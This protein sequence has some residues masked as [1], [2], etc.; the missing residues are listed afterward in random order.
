MC[1]SNVVPVADFPTAVKRWLFIEP[2]RG[3]RSGVDGGDKTLAWPKAVRGVDDPITAGLA[4][5]PGEI[6]IPR[7]QEILE[8]GDFT[9]LL[10]DET[11]GRAAAL[12]LPR[13]SRSSPCCVPA[14]SPG[15]GLILL[16][17][18]AAAGSIPVAHRQ[19]RRAF[20]RTVFRRDRSPA[21]SETR[22]ASA[23]QWMAKRK[24]R[25]T[26]RKT[27]E[28]EPQENAV[29]IKSNDSEKPNTSPSAIEPAAHTRRLVCN[30]R[31]MH[32]PSRSRAPNLV[33]TS[34]KNNPQKPLFV[35][36]RE[37]S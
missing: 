32:R 5:V 28:L 2:S 22:P 11:S 7:A 8:T 24:L 9:P 31:P 18:A 19:R 36:I 27:D 25:R 16:C 29:Y 37:N 1:S 17:A 20:R 13:R 21:R 26:G 15:P 33:A 3:Y 35:K 4:T 14:F 12:P 23:A 6:Q 34:Q 30:V 10:R